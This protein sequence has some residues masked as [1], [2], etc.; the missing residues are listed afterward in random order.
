MTWKPW[1]RSPEQTSL[2]E[3]IVRLARDSGPGHTAVFDLDGCLFDTRPRQT[4][5]LREYASRTGCYEL[6]AVETEHFVDWSLPTT[7]RNAGLDDS[8]IEAHNKP[9][10]AFWWERFFDGAY[11][12]HDLPMPGAVQLVQAVHAAGLHCVYLTGRH[13]PM[14]AGTADALRRHGF[15]FDDGRS[16]LVVKGAIED[17]DTQFKARALEALDQRGSIVL[18]M[19]NEPSNVNVFAD[20]HP[21]ALV[22][23]LDT[24]HSPRPLAAYENL[25]R[26]FG[27]LA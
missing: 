10:L 22:V 17:D 13:T 24:D 18:F 5:I 3:R 6:Y 20:L 1:H 12:V 2:L 8:F 27:F 21:G 7:L 11:H 19:D 25:P 26:L 4:Y 9:L 14:R 16:H 15:P 23:W